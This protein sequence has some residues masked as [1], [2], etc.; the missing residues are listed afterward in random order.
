MTP[1][2]VDPV[3]GGSSLSARGGPSPRR[4]WAGITRL[5]LLV[6]GPGLIPTP[7]PRRP[8]SGAET[9]DGN[10]DSRVGWGF[11]PVPWTRASVPA[12]TLLSLG[13]PPLFSS[14]FALFVGCQFICWLLPGTECSAAGFWGEGVRHPP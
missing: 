12:P 8:S 5:E 7:T 2:H 4:P 6:Q 13:P 3:A 14:C 9:R 1:Q 11:V 10:D